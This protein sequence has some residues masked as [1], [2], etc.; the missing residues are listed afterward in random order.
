MTWAKDGQ[1]S[2]GGQ[3]G[4][5]GGIVMET[6]IHITNA[7]RVQLLCLQKDFPNLSHTYL[8]KTY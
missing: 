5:G 2:A 7:A 4:G 6:R 3:D 1:L 8:P